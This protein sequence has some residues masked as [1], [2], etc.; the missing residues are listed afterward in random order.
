MITHL[1]N[2]I[3]LTGR[4]GENKTLEK[5]YLIAMVMRH[6]QHTQLSVCVWFHYFERDFF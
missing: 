4:G 6:T 5:R 3:R 1:Q 2:V